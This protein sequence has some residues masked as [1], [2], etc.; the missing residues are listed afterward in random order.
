[1]KESL[2]TSG[3]AVSSP[4]MPLLGPV[5]TLHTP[6]GSPARSASTAIASAEN[7][8]WLA[9]RITPV[10][11]APAGAGFAGDHRRRKIPRG[12]GGEHAGRLFL[13]DDAAACP[14]WNGVAVDPLAFLGEPFDKGGGIGD[15]TALSASVLPCS[16]VMMR[17]R[18]S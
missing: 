14:L 4:P 2:R 6:A 13:H 10:Q 16:A 5:I 7:G 18:S 3:L 9:G 1:M 8:V 17:A 11:P 12:D 15:L